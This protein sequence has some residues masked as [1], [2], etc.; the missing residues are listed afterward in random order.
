MNRTLS[1]LSAALPL[2]LVPMA[3]HAN[4]VLDGSFESPS[5]AGTTNGWCNLNPFADP[6]LTSC[7]AQGV[8]PT[9]G[10][11]G[12]WV[13]NLN[14]YVSTSNPDWSLNGP[15]ADGSQFGVLQS[16]SSWMQSVNVVV[17]GPYLLTWSDAGRGE[18]PG[19]YGGDQT[20]WV[21]L[22]GVTLATYSTFSGQAFIPHQMVLQLTAGSHSLR[23][24]GQTVSGDQSAY[25][26][27]I[28]LAPVPEPST[29][30]LLAA[31]LALSIALVPGL[32]RSS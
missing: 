9:L 22:D 12:P 5:V 10:T 4:V 16:R 1:I 15:V 18:S 25:V 11:F 13:G 23:F 32:G 21:R 26:D 19:A 20:Y 3:V 28:S 14:T 2:V 27:A 7:K 6:D 31:G 24:S 17:P 8:E 29:A 30:A